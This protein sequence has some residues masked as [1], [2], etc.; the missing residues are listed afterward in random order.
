MRLSSSIITT[1]IW[2]QQT[3]GF[4]LRQDA[5]F[6]SSLESRL[7][8]RDDGDDSAGVIAGTFNQLIDHDDPSHGTFK[9]RYW[10]SLNYA[11]GSAPP[12]VL[13]S[14]VD[15]EAEQVKFWLHDDYVIGGMIARRLGAAMLMLENRYFGQS[16]PYQE[17][18]TEH[19]KFYTEDQI[20]RD[21]V[22]FAENVELPWAKNGSS[23]PDQVPWVQTGCSAQGNRALFTQRQYPGTFWAS[24]VSSAPPQAISD[25]WRYF[26]AAKA[27]IP[28]NCTADVEKVIEHL[29]S[30]MTHG[31]KDEIQKIK[32]D[33][34]A[35]DLKHNDDFMNLLNYGPQTYQGA[36]LRIQ[37]TWKF[38]D[39]VEN[40]VDVTDPSELPGSE[41]VGLNRALK[42]YSRWVKEVWIPGR[43]EEQ[44]PWKG[45]NNTGCFNFGDA[46]SLVYG[47]KKLNDSG[48]ADTIQLQWLLCNE[49]EEYWQTGSPVGTP[50]LVSRLVN[51]EFFRKTC[52]R[53]FP[54]G[55]NGETYGL[56]KGKTTESWNAH[57]GGWSDPSQHIKRTVLV[58]G[59]FDP[60][61]GASYASQQRPGGILGNSTYIK[62]FLNPM[63]NHCTDTYRNAGTI[64]P[65]V[66]AIQDAGIDQIVDWVAEFK[67]GK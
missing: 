61:R 51:R 45:T 9:Q 65:E 26:D 20:I 46:D 4:A 8:T 35:P 22:Y 3:S 24:W 40:A 39:Y 64:W 66:K 49:P 47:T 36:S 23:R 63:G 60:W 32:E 15:A 67:P 37:D 34:G 27:Y 38:C 13:I 16:S 2:L 5:Y 41:G 62:H 28:I 53:Y 42:G 10:Y 11:N 57:Y 50:T 1:S 25:Y 56:A 29:D 31:S 7:H 55:P 12:V 33:F 48:I 58:N 44:G 6:E 43:C 14:P 21:K 30:I 18:T 52:A 19:L 59:Q 54:P 17:L